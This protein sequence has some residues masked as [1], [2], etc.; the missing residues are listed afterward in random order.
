VA[1]IKL[2]A[3]VQV[4]DTIKIVGTT[5][6]FEQPIKSMEVEHKKIE[7]AKAGES[8]GLKVEERVRES[9]LVYKKLK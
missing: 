9:D 3:P 8:I 5:T 7:K 4:G 1:V 6:N 2:K